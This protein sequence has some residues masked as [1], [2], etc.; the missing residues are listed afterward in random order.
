MALAGVDF[1]GR[2]V[3]GDADGSTAKDQGQGQGQTARLHHGGGCV[4]VVVAG[5]VGGG[6]L[7]AGSCWSAR[8]V[9]VSAGGVAQI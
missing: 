7:S 3:G 6:S 1:V 9:S 2:T 8:S 5:M 4:V